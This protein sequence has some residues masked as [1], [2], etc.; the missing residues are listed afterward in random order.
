LIARPIFQNIRAQRLMLEYDDERSGSFQP[1]AYIP[2]DK[3]AVLGLVT[4]KTPR[5]ETVEELTTRIHEAAQ[6]IDLER[7]ALSPQC[8]FST[9]IVG[10]AITIEDERYKLRTIIETAEAIWEE[11]FSSR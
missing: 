10:N 2:D 4:T 6:Y 3:T 1:L 7:L 5:R 11:S 9:S 8:G